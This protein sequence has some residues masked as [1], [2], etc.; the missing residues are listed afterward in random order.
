M[1]PTFLRL[2]TIIL[3]SHLKTVEYVLASR[4]S[5]IRTLELNSRYYISAMPSS[6]YNFSRYGLTSKNPFVSHVT[7]YMYK[8]MNSDF[9]HFIERV[10]FR[11]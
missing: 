5:E 9:V 11:Y 4:L 3:D 10:P 8:C 7:Y 1:V 6:F 2:A